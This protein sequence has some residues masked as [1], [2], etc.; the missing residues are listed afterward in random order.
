MMRYL[1]IKNCWSVVK[2]T[3]KRPQDAPAD[4][5]AEDVCST[6]KLQNEWDEK[7]GE[8]VGYIF[9]ACSDPVKT[10]VIREENAKSMWDKL[11]NR[12]DDAA[13]EIGRSSL[14]QQLISARPHPDEDIST[15]ANRLLHFQSRLESTSMHV[16]NE[17]VK[18]ILFSTLDDDY[19]ATITFLQ[20][21]PDKTLDECI[22]ALE[23][24]AASKKIRTERRLVHGDA[25]HT[26]TARR[27]SMG[28]NLSSG[29]LNSATGINRPYHD[30]T[31]GVGC[32]IHKS[33]S[34]SDEQCRLQQSQE[35][36]SRIP[37]TN[38][39]TYKRKHDDFSASNDR[40]NGR[41]CYHC[42][43]PD[44][45]KRD[46]PIWKRVLNAQVMMDKKQKRD[47]LTTS[48]AKIAEIVGDGEGF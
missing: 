7:N 2:G 48:D 39:P 5:S 15:Y 35:T 22:N 11:S 46:C 19:E 33:N 21:Y 23:A 29:R 34:H 17:A 47:H 9:L 27:T 24:S 26:S 18:N 20:N 30:Y 12:L 32:R 42:A 16:T 4:A 14:Y 31:P 43:Q 1:Q 8:A 28:S 37:C 13:S 44:H 40:G 3:S 38:Q 6:L 10:F 45:V 41:L 25:L 36:Q